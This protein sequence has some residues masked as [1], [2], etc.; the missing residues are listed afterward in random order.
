MIVTIILVIG[1]I[2]ASISRIK[3]KNSNT[4]RMICDGKT[5]WIII[6]SI[7]TVLLAMACYI[8][9]NTSE[10]AIFLLPTLMACIMIGGLDAMIFSW[11][12]GIIIYDRNGFQKGWMPFFKKYYDYSEL[13]S[14][15]IEEKKVTFF[16][17]NGKQAV[18]VNY[19]K[20]EYKGFFEFVCVV[21]ERTCGI[22][23]ISGK[24]GPQRD[25]FNGNIKDP[26]PHIVIF[27]LLILIMCGCAVTAF[28][29]AFN[30]YD[31]TDA[32]YFETTL[33][34]EA[35][36][37]DGDLIFSAEGVDHELRWDNYKYYDN[38]LVS[39]F[40]FGVKTGKTYQ[41]YGRYFPGGKYESPFYRMY[42]IKDMEGK[43]YITFALSNQQHQNIWRIVS[44]VVSVFLFLLV[45]FFVGTIRVGRHPEKYSKRVR[46]IF[47]KED[48]FVRKIE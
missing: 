34:Y 3:N 43:E 32:K 21:Y 48:S 25:L 24:Y 1:C 45:L 12:N 19:E 9:I 31:E 37:D 44:A 2:S 6:A 30:F 46:N 16:F 33:V 20:K 36:T 18:T 7:A 4:S 47:F 39:D 40:L 17:H 5:A 11:L 8:E 14:Y 35:Y 22:K 27:V 23:L 13:T 10:M 15:Y 28:Y 26:N 41:I 38:G 29:E 42:Q